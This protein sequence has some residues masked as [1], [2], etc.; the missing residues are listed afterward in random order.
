[1]I[2]YIQIKKRN[3]VNKMTN[4]KAI[5][6][7]MDGTIANLYGVEGWLPMLRA[8]NATPYAQAKTMVDMRVLARLLNK[9]QR[10]GY[11][12]GVVSWLAKG[13]NEQYDIEVTN[14]KR[15]WLATHLKS[16]QWD[17]V[18]IVAYGTPKHNIVGYPNGILFD[19]EV[20]NRNMWTG[21]AYDVQDIVGIIKE[22]LRE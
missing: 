3:E 15:K 17:E 7:D 9:A 13:S 11:T 6:F 21:T 19:D 4:T 16:V 20:H 14:A 2:Y 1:M 5:Y 8:H 22:L 18:H 12:I 10:E